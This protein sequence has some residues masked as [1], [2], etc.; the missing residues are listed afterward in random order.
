MVYDNES[1]DFNRK[2][3]IEYIATSIN[4]NSEKVNYPF[5]LYII[6]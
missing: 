5:K 6:Q 3:E 1:I 4:N 2:G